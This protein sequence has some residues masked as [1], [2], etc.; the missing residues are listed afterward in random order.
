MLISWLRFGE[1]PLDPAYVPR[2]L[3]ALERVAVA[4]TEIDT[5]SEPG[6]VIDVLHMVATTIQVE[7]P[8]EV[9]LD[10]YVALLQP[11]PLHVLRLAAYEIMQT[12]TMRTL[13][14]PAEFLKTT[15]VVSW[16]VARRWLPMMLCQW[17]M[18][19]KKIATANAGESNGRIPD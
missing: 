6:E 1:S 11:L 16:Y 15:E 19:L 17:E 2:A 12:H 8:S 9:G 10:A 3:A 4:F 13:P 14:L 7:L 5:G 18:Q